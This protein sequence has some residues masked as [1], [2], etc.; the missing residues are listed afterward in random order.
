MA[1]DLENSAI[2]EECEEGAPGW[3]TTFGDMMS[4]LLTFFILLFSMSTVNEMKFKQILESIQSSLG[5]TE[6]PQA[7]TRE[8]LEMISK[9]AEKK[10]NAVDELGGMVQK[11]MEEILSDIEEFVMKNKLGGQVKSIIDSR[12]AVI[13]VSDVVLFNVGES[14]ITE[15]GLKLTDQLVELLKEFDYRVRVEGHTDNIPIHTRQFPS[16]WELSSARASSLVRYFIEHGI[17]PER[18]SAEGFAEFRPIADN[19]TPEGRAK[20]RRVEVV[21]VR[22]DIISKIAK[23]MDV[24]PAKVK[25]Q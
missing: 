2:E 20:N 21:Y 18:L 16:N 15:E 8:G 12:G 22:E 13:I 23:D 9:E 14:V 11:E 19:S 1:E 25:M 17:P 5:V 6:V 4:L 24:D 7:G 3:M 10:E